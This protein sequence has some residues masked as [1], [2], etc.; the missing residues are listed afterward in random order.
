MVA[1]TASTKRDNPKIEL[2]GVETGEKILVELDG[3]FGGIAKA[4]VTGQKKAT[5]I[6]SARRVF[7][8]LESRICI[9]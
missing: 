1:V 8:L 6:G 4:A 2:A 3:W 5:S 7:E 9:R